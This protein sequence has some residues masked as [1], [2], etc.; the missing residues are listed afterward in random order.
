MEGTGK[1]KIVGFVRAIQDTPN[2]SM[3]FVLQQYLGLQYVYSLF[4]LNMRLPAR[5]H[6]YWG[7]YV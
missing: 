6:A 3:G 1:E 2:N 4:V 5:V 7:V